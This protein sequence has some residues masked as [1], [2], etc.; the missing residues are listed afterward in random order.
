MSGRYLLLTQIHDTPGSKEV[1][2]KR[3][4]GAE[5]ISVIV[6]TD[7]LDAG[8]LPEEGEEEDA[9]T[10]I[11]CTIIIEK[12]AGALEISAQAESEAFFIDNV[13]HCDSSALASDT[14]V[15]ADWKRRGLFAGPVLAS[16][17]GNC[18]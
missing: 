8:E 14:S 15:E 11:A 4:F 12:D 13:A 1:T 3:T 18:F 6:S 17:L 10:P 2:L 9:E 5:K 7:A 16:D